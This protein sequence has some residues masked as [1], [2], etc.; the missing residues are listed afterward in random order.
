MDDNEELIADSLIN[1]LD[2]DNITYNK[3]IRS[4]VVPAVG[5]LKDGITLKVIFIIPIIVLIIG[6]AVWRYRK[7]KK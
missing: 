1:L 3:K 2:D 5:I 6:Y 4:E 7:N